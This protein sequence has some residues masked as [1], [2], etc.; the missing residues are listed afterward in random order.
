MTVDYSNQNIE[1]GNSM[2]DLPL[3]TGPPKYLNL[4][5][6]RPQFSTATEFVIKSII[7]FTLLPHA[8]TNYE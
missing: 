8:L 3:P 4:N 2:V 6:K 5:Y 7:L 1:P